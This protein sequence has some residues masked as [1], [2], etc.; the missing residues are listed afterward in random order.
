M[1][2][3]TY[4][5]YHSPIVSPPEVRTIGDRHSLIPDTHPLLELRQILRVTGRGLRT[6]LKQETERPQTQ[7]GFANLLDHVKPWPVGTTS[8]FSNLGDD[9]IESLGEAI[10]KDRQDSLETF[11]MCVASVRVSD[12]S[13]GFVTHLAT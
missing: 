8:H 3:F 2:D 12:E 10:L 7:R 5:S 9:S 13:H 1:F 11:A 6:I 4:C